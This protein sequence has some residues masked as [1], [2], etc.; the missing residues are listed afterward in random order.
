MGPAVTAS[1]Q[2]WKK[3]DYSKPSKDWKKNDHEPKHEPKGHNDYSSKDH[4]D[5]EPKHDKK[6]Y[7]SKH[8]PSK[9]YND[10]SKDEPHQKD[11]KAYS[12]LEA[13]AEEK[14]LIDDESYEDDEGAAFIYGFGCSSSEIRQIGQSCSQGC[15]CIEGCCEGAVCV[16]KQRDWTNIFLYCPADCRGKPFGPLGS[17]S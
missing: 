13:E 14:V 3:S 9:D 2:H 12:L 1:P 8:E 15:E 6:V 5:Y 7:P 17:C 16:A 10:Y 11:G 4:K